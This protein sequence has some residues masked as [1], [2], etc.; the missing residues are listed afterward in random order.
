MSKPRDYKAE[1]E[2][3]IAKGLS[4]GLSRSQARGHPRPA[5]THISQSLQNV[6]YDKRLELGLKELRLGKSLTKSAKSTGVSRERLS[7]YLAKNSVIEKHNGRWR[8]KQDDRIREVMIYSQGKAKYIQVK[9]YESAS[10]VGRYIDAVG[11]FLK[12]NNP[13][14]LD[15]FMDVVVRDIKGKAYSLET[16]PNILYRLEHAGGETFEQVYRIVV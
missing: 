7:H 2:R 11:Q 9:G 5:E 1:Y 13:S 8:L 12:T 15:S 4:K 6:Q 10:L 3:R 14:H 16:R